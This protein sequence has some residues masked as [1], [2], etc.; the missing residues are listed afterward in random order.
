MADEL[1]LSA[2]ESIEIPS[3]ESLVVLPIPQA[4]KDLAPNC[5]WSMSGFD[6]SGVVWEDDLSKRPSDAD[7]L[8]RA[9]EILAEAPMRMLRRQRD[10]RMREV[11][12]VTLRS[13]RTG[14]PVPEDWKDYMQA[15][16]DITKTSNPTIADGVLIGVNWPAR[17]DGEPAGLYRG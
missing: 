16:A 5:R 12:W 14:E 10:A 6:I 1:D 2:V 9:R 4:I 3:P 11:D 17:P 8:K 13:A 15:L 7:V